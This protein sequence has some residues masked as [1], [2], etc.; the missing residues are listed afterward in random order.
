MI[1]FVSVI[2]CGITNYPKTQSLTQE[3]FITLH[4]FWGWEPGN[5]LTGW[6]WL[7]F[8]SLMRWGSGWWGR[9]AAVWSYWGWTIFF[10]GGSLTWPLAGGPSFFP[11]HLGLPQGCLS[12]PMT[13]QQASPEGVIESG[14]AGG[15]GGDSIIDL[16]FSLKLSQ[17][18][19]L[20]VI[21][22]MRNVC[23]TC[24]GF[25]SCCSFPCL[26]AYGVIFIL[27][28]NHSIEINVS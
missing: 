25:I 20:I 24:I 8:W 6:F 21:S 19:M 27:M 28:L 7:Q 1:S 23:I 4:G 10:S 22:Q 15:G 26:S 9:A 16:G 11:Y 3:P 18:L 13:W 14:M 5:G 2:Y 17:V 12:V